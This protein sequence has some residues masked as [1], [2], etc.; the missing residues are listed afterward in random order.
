MPGNGKNGLPRRDSTFLARRASLAATDALRDAV[1]VTKGWT[2]P[3]PLVHAGNQRELRLLGNEADRE[4]KSDADFLRQ[5]KTRSSAGCQM[6]PSLR[7]Y[8][9]VGSSFRWRISKLHGVKVTD[10]P[11]SSETV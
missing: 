9:G 5:N 6:K 2:V 1:T 8:T 4:T 11:R 3:L 10:P 7:T